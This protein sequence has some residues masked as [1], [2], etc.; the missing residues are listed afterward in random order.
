VATGEEE[1]RRLHRELHDSLGPVLTGAALKADAAALQ[2]MV[3]PARAEALDLELAD[4]L[5]EAISDLRRI[6]YGLRPP[7]LDELGLVGALRRQEGQLGPVT[8]TVT[9]PEELPVLP[10]AVEVTAYRVATEAVANVVRHAGAST[11]EVSLTATPAELTVSVTDDGHSTA[12]WV[13]GVGLR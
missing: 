11:A 1:R 3:D 10:A 12:G 13:P 4:Q 7:A 5:R 8:L 6:V 2:A 9:A